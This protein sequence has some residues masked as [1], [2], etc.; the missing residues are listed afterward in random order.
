MIER[1]GDGGH[2]VSPRTDRVRA[3]RAR[4]R[5]RDF[6]DEIL[7]EGAKRDPQFQQLVDSAYRRRA[8][9][10]RLVAARRRSGLT[11]AEIADRMRT[12]QAAVAR[13][14]TGNFDVR[15]TTLDRYALAVGKRITYRLSAA[16]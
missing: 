15:T 11:Q 8:L 10:H 3:A 14:E 12:S 9:L 2:R 1:E 6:L 7:A 13:I 5:S 16:T 4:R